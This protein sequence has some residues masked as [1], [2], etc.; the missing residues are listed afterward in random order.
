[1][2]E[3][4]LAD[5]D[6]VNIWECMESNLSSHFL[7]SI[8]TTLAGS[9]I[10]GAARDQ[11]RRLASNMGID[12]IEPALLIRGLRRKGHVEIETNIKGH[13]VRICAVPPTLY[14][15]PIKDVEQRQVYGVCGSLRLQQWKELVQATDCRVFVEKTMSHNLPVI[16]VVPRSPS[17]I[18][19][20]AKVAN[21]QVVEFPVQQLS[22][23]L[24]SIKEIKNNIT[25][26]P[27]QGFKPNDMKKL[28]PQRSQ[29]GTAQ[30]M[31]VD[32]SRK[33]E[34][35]RY[36]DP[37]IQGMNVYKLGK[38]L[39]DSF[40]TY[41]F[42]QDSRWGVWM[43]VGAFAEWIKNPP[44]SIGDASPWPFHYDTALGSL[45]IPARMEPPYVIE[46]AL[47]LCAGDGPLVI[48]VTGEQHGD[49]LLLSEKGQGMIG[50]VSRVYSDMASGKWLCYR[51]VPKVIASQI[52]SLL[53]GELKV[54]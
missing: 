6:G 45:W 49:S 37:Q 53:G 40:S 52:A 38:N 18:S 35:F 42:I 11:I 3:K 13:M 4:T 32:P 39:G 47:A 23:W 21:F 48:E 50:K 20:I 54:I 25:W 36:E 19:E 34:L 51:W 46:R 1:V 27:E 17:A 7:D 22:Q 14:S 16:R 8:A 31:L 5:K 26:Y 41:S 44:Y 2:D 24:G 28:N 9:M 29:F 15:L 30:S 33:Y 10:Y 12:D 43:A